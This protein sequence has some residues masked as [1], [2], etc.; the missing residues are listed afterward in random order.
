MLRVFRNGDGAPCRGFQ[1]ASTSKRHRRPK[2]ATAVM[3][4]R[5]GRKGV[6]EANRQGPQRFHWRVIPPRVIR[7][8]LWAFTARMAHSRRSPKLL[9]PRVPS[10]RVH[11]L[12][13][14]V[15]SAQAAVFK[16][17]GPG[18]D[19]RAGPRRRCASPPRPVPAPPDTRDGGS[20]L[21][22]PTQA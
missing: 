9:P 22:I 2:K 21:T 20:R 3:D 1:C 18:P 19:G 7:L 17:P 16:A 15:P 12:A 14:W 8:S 13:P 6:G 5:G 4:S 11:T 10:R